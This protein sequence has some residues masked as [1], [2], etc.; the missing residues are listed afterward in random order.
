ML[1]KSWVL[2]LCLLAGLALGPGYFVYAGFFGGAVVADPA[3]R[4]A[5]A[6]AKGEGGAGLATEAAPHVLT[7]R[8]DPG[9]NPIAAVVKLQ[10]L[11]NLS[12][13]QTR[14]TEVVLTLSRGGAPLWT[15]SASFTQ[16]RVARDRDASLDPSAAVKRDAFRTLVKRF[17]VEAADDYSLTLAFGAR[18]ELQVT[19]FGLELRRNTRPPDLAILSLGVMLLT[20]ALGG[21]WLARRQRRTR[22]A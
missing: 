19:A 2:W 4:F 12:G 16:P 5:E 6:G 13:T 21:F 20:I 10:A 18:N 7:L 14:A 22:G 1:S 3:W 11:E 8:L 9:M 15:E 17:D